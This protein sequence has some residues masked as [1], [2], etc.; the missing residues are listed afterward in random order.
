MNPE[1]C[2][3]VHQDDVGEKIL[4]HQNPEP[5]VGNKENNKSVSSKT[6]FPMA[7]TNFNLERMYIYDG[8][9]F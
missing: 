6:V 8:Y 7:A 3:N 9:S 5:T 1:S 2:P 4:G